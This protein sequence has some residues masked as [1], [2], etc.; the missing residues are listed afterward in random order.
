MGR[1]IAH[2]QQSGGQA[3]RS[4][5]YEGKIMGKLLAPRQGAALSEVWFSYSRASAR[6]ISGRRCGQDTRLLRNSHTATNKMRGVSGNGG[7]AS[8]IAASYEQLE[9]DSVWKRALARFSHWHWHHSSRPLDVLMH[10]SREGRTK[11]NREE[12][13]TTNEHGN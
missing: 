8:K 3:Q 6:H 9:H 10:V 5:F 2:P 4:D 12:P 1:G 11:E 7:G 13:A